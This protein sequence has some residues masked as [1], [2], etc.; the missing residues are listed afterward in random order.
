[1][2]SS[3]LS[4]EEIFALD[5]A[6]KAFDD[7]LKEVLKSAEFRQYCWKRHM[8]RHD[9]GNRNRTTAVIMQAMQDCGESIDMICEVTGLKYSTISQFLD[10][11]Q[12]MKI[13]IVSMGY[14]ERVADEKWVNG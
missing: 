14:A 1:M 5:P 3:E 8:A 6:I 2:S 13:S 9:L 12:E 7:K 11:P 4:E 10:A